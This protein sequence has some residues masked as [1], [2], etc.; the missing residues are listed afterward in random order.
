MLSHMMSNPIAGS[1]KSI[2][3][4]TMAWAILDITINWC[5]VLKILEAKIIWR[6]SQVPTHSDNDDTLS[7]WCLVKSNALRFV[8]D[9]FVLSMAREPRAPT[10]N[11]EKNKRLRNKNAKTYWEHLVR[12]RENFSQIQTRIRIGGL[13]RLLRIV[14][15]QE[16]VLLFHNCVLVR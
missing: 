1:V 12:R 9:V 8:Q 16:V 4:W 10:L 6:P 11:L 15:C 2:W 14:S 5:N 3:V 7:S 13:P